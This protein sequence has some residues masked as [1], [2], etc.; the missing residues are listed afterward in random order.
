MSDLTLF[1]GNKVSLKDRKAMSQALKGAADEQQTNQLPDGGVYISFSGKKNQYSIGQ[2][3]NDADPEEIWLVNIYSFEKGWTCWKGGSPAAKRMASVY[4]PPVDT[5]DF[6]EHGPFNEAR[7]E[8]WFSSSAFMLRS[9]DNGVQGY[10]STNTK[11]A[12]NE[13]AKLQTEI[14]RRIDEG[15]PEWPIIQLG[16]EEFK[17][18]GQVNGKPKLLVYGWLGDNQVQ[19]MAQMDDLAD[20]ADSVDD[21]IAEADEEWQKRVISGD[22]ADDDFYDNEDVDDVADDDA[23]D[24]GFDAEEDDDVG[25]VEEPAPTQSRRSRRDRKEPD[26]PK[27]Q[28]RRRRAAV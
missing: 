1:S 20:I 18:Q 27:A 25:Q 4:G 16:R 8:G 14:S 26:Q 7:G 19:K 24:D 12:L 23:G 6:T 11:S 9:L 3:K 5:P 22:G 21:L 13:F 28:G 17:A 15:E 10:F 2:E